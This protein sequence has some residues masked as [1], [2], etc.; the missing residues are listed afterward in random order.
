MA[1]NKGA[2][3]RNLQNPKDFESLALDHL[4]RAIQ[5][6]QTHTQSIARLCSHYISNKRLIDAKELVEE[7]LTLDPRNQDLVYLQAILLYENSE[8]EKALQKIQSFL[9]TTHENLNFLNLARKLY[10]KLNDLT[11]LRYTVEK[12]IEIDP[13]NWAHFFCLADILQEPEDYDRA[14]LLLEIAYDLSNG[15]KEVLLEI[16]RRTGLKSF[17]DEE[18]VL[19]RNPDLPKLE[20]YLLLIEKIS[21]SDEHRYSIGET[22]IECGLYNACQHQLRKIKANTASDFYL[23]KGLSDYHL[24]DL[25]EAKFNLSKVKSKNTKYCYALYYL[26]KAGEALSLPGHELYGEKAIVFLN[27]FA[28]NLKKKLEKELIRGNFHKSKLCETELCQINKYITE[29][30]SMN[31]SS[32]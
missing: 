28:S 18:G 30:M 15:N 9:S 14:I 31:P 29:C 26:A 23:L 7:S 21:L 32:G 8:Y 22:L 19:H 16:V 4:K 3:L 6:N 13:N 2:S 17:Y 5:L 1:K 20:K 24:G 27:K 25:Q 11:N 10:Y 12:L